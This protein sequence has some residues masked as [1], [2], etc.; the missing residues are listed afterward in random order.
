[1]R[2]LIVEDE[3]TIRLAIEYQ[4]KQYDKNA[5]ILSFDR[6]TGVVAEL[7]RRPDVAILDLQF[8]DA[9]GENP[10]AG[11]DLALELFEKFGYTPIILLTIRGDFD[12][13][14]KAQEHPARIQYFISKLW[15][16][17]SDLQNAIQFCTSDGHLE[18]IKETPGVIGEL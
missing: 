13:L 16:S 6:S 3:S 18:H 2:I 12:A 14:K 8:P 1:M 7:D 15:W 17:A 10:N 11:F 9:D 5:E 4:V